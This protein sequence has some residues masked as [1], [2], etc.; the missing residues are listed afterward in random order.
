MKNSKKNELETERI[1]L[2]LKNRLFSDS[3]ADQERFVNDSLRDAGRILLM[4]YTLLD[5]KK[6]ISGVLEN[7]GESFELSFKKILPN[8][9]Q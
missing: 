4:A 6:G 2:E 7:R 1:I 5:L 9:E 3:K 8:H